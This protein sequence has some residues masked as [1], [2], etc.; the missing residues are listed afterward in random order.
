MPAVVPPLN[1][2]DYNLHSSLLQLNNVTSVASLWP[3]RMGGQG[4]E[5]P[6]GNGTLFDLLSVCIC[7]LYAYAIQCMTGPGLLVCL[8]HV[9]GICA[10]LPPAVEGECKAGFLPTGASGSAEAA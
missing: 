8:F 9:G 10:A 1:F 3:Y 6:G 4:G 2:A 5:G 7:P